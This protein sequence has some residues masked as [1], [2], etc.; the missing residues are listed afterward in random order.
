MAPLSRLQLIEMIA[1][2]GAAQEQLDAQA[3]AAR[4][5]EF[6]P[7]GSTWIASEQRDSPPTLAAS[8]EHASPEALSLR[9][10]L[11]RIAPAAGSDGLPNGA[12]PPTGAR[13]YSAR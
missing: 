8:P 1:A 3:A 5:A 13:S 11:A 2:E 10:S 6:E 9:Q 7:L 12:L 4:D